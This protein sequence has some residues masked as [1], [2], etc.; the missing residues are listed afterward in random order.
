MASLGERVE[1]LS[2]QKPLTEQVAAV[3][4]A[5]RALV[6]AVFLTVGHSAPF[7]PESDTSPQLSDA[8][9]MKGLRSEV[10]ALAS[11]ELGN[12]RERAA[13][14][15]FA[16]AELVAALDDSIEAAATTTEIRFQARRIQRDQDTPFARS[17]WIESA[18]LASLGTLE[19]MKSCDRG[20][21]DT[22]IARARRSVSALPDRGSVVFDHAR[23][24]DAFRS[25]IDAFGVA[26]MNAKDCP[27]ATT[28]AAE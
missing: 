23:I 14:A 6:D 18:L 22:W 9:L 3:A 4:S 27:P 8:A 12:V 11:A 1:A 7:A 21:T 2:D 26:L 10:L 13:N 24:Q 20:A 15:L 28:A 16:L 17:D 5:L 25:T 19:R